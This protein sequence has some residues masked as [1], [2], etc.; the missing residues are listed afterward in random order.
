MGEGRGGDRGGRGNNVK[1]VT[2]LYSGTYFHVEIEL[3]R[4]SLCIVGGLF[5]GGW[6]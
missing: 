6:K 3:A 1:S 2:I 4:L 5:W